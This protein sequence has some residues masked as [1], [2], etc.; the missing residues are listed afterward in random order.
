[1]TICDDCCG[2]PYSC[3]TKLCRNNLGEL[4][5]ECYPVRVERGGW[6]SGFSV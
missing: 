4:A 6:F 1:M 2:L 3:I 5:W